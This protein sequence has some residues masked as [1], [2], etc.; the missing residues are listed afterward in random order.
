MVIFLS[1][2]VFWRGLT[3][4]KIFEGFKLYWYG[5]KLFKLSRCDCIWISPRKYHLSS[6]KPIPIFEMYIRNGSEIW[7]LPSIAININLICGSAS[8]ISNDNRFRAHVMRVQVLFIT[9]CDWCL[10]NSLPVGVRVYDYHQLNT[11]FLLFGIFGSLI[12]SLP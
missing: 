7:S 5:I 12:W 11:I 8:C 9:D 3:K 10:H 6:L 1:W 4:F 2:Q